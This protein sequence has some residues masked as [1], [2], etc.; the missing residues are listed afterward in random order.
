MEKVKEN[1]QPSWTTIKT[2]YV[3]KHSANISFHYFPNSLVT[4]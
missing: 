4:F 3:I 2:N 1:K